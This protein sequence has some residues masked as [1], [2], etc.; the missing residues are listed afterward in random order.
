MRL[1]TIVPTLLV[2][3]SAAQAVEFHGVEISGFASLGYVNS[4]SNEYLAEGSESGSWQMNNVGLNFGYQA[5]D[6]LRFAAQIYASNLGNAGEDAQYEDDF[7]APTYSWK[8]GGVGLDLLFAQYTVADEFGIRL[9]RVKQPFGLYNEVRDIDAVRGSATL[10]Q[11]VYDDRSREYDFAVNG[12]SIFGSIGA[13][14]A[15]SFDYQVFG[16]TIDVSLNGSVAN[17]YV[18]PEFT[19]EEVTVG[20]IYG[21]QLIWNAPID[22]LRFGFSMR[23]TRD[24]DAK[25]AWNSD[26]VV[27]SGV[28]PIPYSYSLPDESMEASTDTDNYMLSVEFTYDSFLFQA[29]YLRTDMTQ[30]YSTSKLTLVADPAFL[31]EQSY[32]LTDDR[33]IS[34]GWYVMAS[35]RP[36][37]QIELGGF[38]S[39][40][41]A[42]IANRS[43]KNW[44]DY[45]NDFALFARVDTN[46]EGLMFKVEGHVVRG[47]ALLDVPDKQAGYLAS[48]PTADENWHYIV[49]KAAYSF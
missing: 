47:T 31:D 13:G 20:S 9:G 8:N 44:N 19:L 1:I 42:D 10:P 39:F 11:A 41:T 4:S 35:Y 22:G 27:A 30:S 38:G 15:G 34:E 40:Y 24:R 49:V 37:E 5:T 17:Q 43:T 12:G 21:G 14:K 48:E 3:A 2:A 28:V 23:Q 46:V 33:S 45:Q 18:T 6:R 16:G 25:V 36:V 7:L 32:E 26:L 29:E